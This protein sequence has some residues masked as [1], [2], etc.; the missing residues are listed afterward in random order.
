MDSERKSSRA[1]NIFLQSPLSPKCCIGIKFL[2]HELRD[3]AYS[4]YS[5]QLESFSSNLGTKKDDDP[6]YHGDSEKC[7]HLDR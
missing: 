1:Q 6:H 3:E 7:M 5:S 2:T 4:G